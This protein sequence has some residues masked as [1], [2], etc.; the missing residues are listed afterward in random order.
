MESSDIF[1]AFAG[2]TCAGCQG[3]KRPYNGFCTKC[4][5]QLPPK[6]KSALWQRFGS[7]FEQAY[8]ACLSWYREHP[9]QGKHRANQ[10]RLFE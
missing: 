7:G 5:Q 8:M 6:L 9:F 2:K 1:A 3:P 4:Y 10:Q